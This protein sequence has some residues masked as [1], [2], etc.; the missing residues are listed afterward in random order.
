MIDHETSR[1][2]LPIAPSLFVERVLTLSPSLMYVK[3]SLGSSSPLTSTPAVAHNVS[4][5]TG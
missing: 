3:Y 2:G 1:A 4:E 5:K